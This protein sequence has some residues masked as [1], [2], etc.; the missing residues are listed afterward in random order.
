MVGL[1][2]FFYLIGSVLIMKID[3]FSYGD[4]LYYSFITLSTI[5]FGDFYQAEMFENDHLGK[6]V[7]MTLFMFF[8]VLIGLSITASLVIV[9]ASTIKLPTF[10]KS[11]VEKKPNNENLIQNDEDQCYI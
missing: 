7:G 9:M 5:G 6:Q 4:A 10:T 3:E 2:L 1:F 8:W 11:K